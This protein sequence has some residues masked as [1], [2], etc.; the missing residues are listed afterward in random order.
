MT[1]TTRY[2]LALA[3]Y[4]LA[5]VVVPAGVAL[6][7]LGLSGRSAVI[8][9]GL[10]MILILIGERGFRRWRRLRMFDGD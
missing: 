3:S 4:W 9:A 1:S 8:V 2:R 5:F 10:A 7:F 6:A